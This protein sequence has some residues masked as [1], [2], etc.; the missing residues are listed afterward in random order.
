[1]PVGAATII[2]AG[3]TLLGG[4]LSKPKPKYVVPDYMGIKNAAEAAGFNPLTALTQ[5]PAGSVVDMA[6]G[7]GASIAEAGLMLADNLKKASASSKLSQAQSENAKLREKVTN[8]TLRPKVAG[9]YAQRQAVPS[10]AGALGA[11]NAVSGGSRGV[12]ADSGVQSDA[13]ASP[14]ATPDKL[15]PR[16]PVKVADVVSDPGY[17][18]LDNPLLPKARIPSLNGEIPDIG[19]LPWIGGSLAFAYGEQM[20]NE[21]LSR[22]WKA[23]LIASY[24]GKPHPGQTATAWADRLREKQRAAAWDW[25]TGKNTSKGW[26]KFQLGY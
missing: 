3:A 2:K 20:A 5:G 26:P 23:D 13:P 12:V 10:L 4:L 24:G 25:V 15:D 6:G 22:K 7:M 21:A 9:I 18:V 11:S 17:I 16:R 1:M 8:L 14:L 19:Q